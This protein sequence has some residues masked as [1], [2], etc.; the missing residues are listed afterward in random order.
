VTVL[1]CDVPARPRLETALGESEERGATA[2]V[3]QAARLLRD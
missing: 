2:F 3:E 1:F